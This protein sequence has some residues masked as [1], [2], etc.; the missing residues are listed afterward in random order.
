MEPMLKLAP[1][2]AVDTRLT[3]LPELSVAVGTAQL[4]VALVAP[5]AAVCKM[6]LGQLLMTGGMLSVV[7]PF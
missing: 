2:V 1:G 7:V 6:L 3:V 4:T 5:G